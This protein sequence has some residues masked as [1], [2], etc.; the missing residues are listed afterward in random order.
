LVQSLSQFENVGNII[1]TFRER[2]DGEGYPSGLRGRKIPLGA[3]V[4]AVVD[5]YETMI[6]ERPYQKCKT[7]H[8]AIDEIKNCSGK[9]FDPVVVEAFL[10]TIVNN[11]NVNMSFRS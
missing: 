3:R 10:R 2:F 5:A 9:Q 6:S 4:L 8:E 7:T 1:R 11:V